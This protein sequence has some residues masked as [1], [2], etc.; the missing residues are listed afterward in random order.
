VA[1]LIIAIFLGLLI[2]FGKI[3]LSVD[4]LFYD[5]NSNIQV[6][7]SEITTEDIILVATNSG[8]KPGIITDVKFSITGKV[9]ENFN[10]PETTVSS[11]PYLTEEQ[12]IIESGALANFSLN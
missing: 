8:S 6:E 1:N 9:I 3:I 4:E 7:I 2:L 5:D 11:G 10:L 12:I